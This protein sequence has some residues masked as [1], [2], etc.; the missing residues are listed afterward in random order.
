MPQ[1]MFNASPLGSGEET[2]LGGEV[3][4]R[5]GSVLGRT[6]GSAC[7]PASEASSTS[8]LR[9]SASARCIAVDRVGVL[10][11][12]APQL[13]AAA[14]AFAI[15]SVVLLGQA[16]S[17]RRGPTASLDAVEPTIVQALTAR[18]KP[19]GRLC[20]CVPTYD[21]AENVGPFVRALL[22]TF[23]AAG[24]DGD[25][26]VVDD[27]SPDGTGVIADELSAEDERVRVLHR[28]AQD[29]SRAR[30]PGRVRAGR[31][32]TVSSSSRRSTA[33]SR[34]TGFAA[35]SGRGHARRRCRDRIALRRR[36]AQSSGWPRSRQLISRLWICLC[37]ARSRTADP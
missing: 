36:R 24:L 30:V 16:Q 1:T 34:T 3:L 21:E 17:M 31:S 13:A 7:E 6:C 8:S 5:D 23:D 19:A 37:P 28:T 26:L 10:V 29:W 27:A 18:L 12:G 32:L 11:F 25:V 4:W 2:D 35:G 20:V 14:A 33:T 9:C 22:E 15:G